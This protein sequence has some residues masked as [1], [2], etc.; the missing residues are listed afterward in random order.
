MRIAI[1]GAGAIGSLYG[2]LLKIA[3]H[4]VVLIGRPNHVLSINDSGLKISGVLGEHTIDIEAT[5]NPHDVVHADYV[6]IT[7]KTY[8]TIR[9]ARDIEHV[10]KAGARVVVLQ[11]G[12]GTERQVAK[13]LGTTAVLRATTCFGAEIVASGAVE[14]TG[15][16]LTEIGSHYD[17]NM[18]AVY[19]FAAALREAGFEVAESDNIDGVVWTKTIV[20]CGIN[21]VGALTGLTNGEIHSNPAL[22]GLVVKLVEE[23][24][25]IVERLGIELTTDDPV[26]YTLG[27]AKATGNNI[28]SMLQ[29]I[30]AMKRT[31][32]E[33]ITGVVITIG[34]ELGIPTPAS[35]SVFALVRALES[36]YLP[37]EE[38]DLEK[39]SLYTEELVRAM[40]KS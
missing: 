18:E 11:N 12:L 13:A 7:T 36:K 31:E 15:Q 30:R 14:V 17:E 22:R 25:L 6:M 8:D 35:R 23:A 38:V 34:Q 21:P 4:D 37:D 1:M 24:S 20:N 39:P 19:E 5:S 2:G 40:T 26:R 16:G 28:N 33:S 9:A 3:G 10:V 27:T 29:D 32:I